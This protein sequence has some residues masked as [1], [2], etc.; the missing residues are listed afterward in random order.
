MTKLPDKQK[1]KKDTK[2]VQKKKH[3]ERTA[4][5]PAFQGA[6][7]LEFSEYLDVLEITPEYPLTCEPLK[8]D[9]LIVKKSL[10]VLLDKNFAHIFKTH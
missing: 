5:H 6:I 2:R 4:W 1:V 9:L 7:E 3:D 10:D 8:I